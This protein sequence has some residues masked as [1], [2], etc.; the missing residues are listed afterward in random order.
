[1]FIDFFYVL[2]KE[3]IPVSIQEFLSFLEALNEGIVNF[4]VEDFYSLCKT[5][6]IKHEQY[7]DRFDIIFGQYFQGVQ[8]VSEAAQ[9][10]I[11]EDWIK[12]E[13]DRMFTEE[14]K[15]MIEAYGGLEEIMKRLEELL[16][17]QKERHQGGNTWIGTGGT[18]P[19]GNGGYNPQGVRVGGSGG[20]RSAIKIWE[21]RQFRDYADDVELNT[22]NIKM[23]LRRLRLLTRDGIEDELDLDTTIDNTCKNAGYIDIAMQASKKNRIKVLLLF[24][25][26]GSMDP[27]VELCSQLFSAAKAEFKHLEFFYFH[28]C[29]YESVWKNNL[30]R[31]DEKT[32][33][34]D[35]FH[36]YNND[37]KVIIVGDATMSP[38][39]LTHSGGSIEHYNDESGVAWLKRIKEH[40]PYTIWLN[41]THE[42][43]WQGTRSIEIIQEIFPKRM[44]PTTIEGLTRAMKELRGKKVRG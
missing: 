12:K 22:R 32:P 34:L 40:F 1:M 41:P 25:V 38:Y 27:H 36:K 20:Q 33:T 15:K 31:W 37:Y 14:E 21:K 26:G 43:F 11:P 8:F 17:I 23:A 13:L 9:K 28:N 30:L 44:F 39:E 18:S 19:F 35:I 42:D 10:E 5:I 24:D 2:K 29:I 4:S 3:G 6:L 16:E 7:L